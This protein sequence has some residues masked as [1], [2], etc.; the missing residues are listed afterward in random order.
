MVSN[1]LRGVEESIGVISSSMED[2][3]MLFPCLEIVLKVKKEQI[4]IHGWNE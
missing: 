4:R 2:E 3:D 1:S